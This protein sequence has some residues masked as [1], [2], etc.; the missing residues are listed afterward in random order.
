MLLFFWADND[1]VFSPGD[2]GS[3]QKMRHKPPRPSFRNGKIDQLR[4]EL[5]DIS[6]FR[7]NFGWIQLGNVSKL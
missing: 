7:E 6:R 5:S 4:L 1:T 3:F 2:I